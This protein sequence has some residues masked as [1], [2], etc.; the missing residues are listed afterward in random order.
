MWFYA[1]NRYQKLPFRDRPFFSRLDAPLGKIVRNSHRRVEQFL[2]L[3]RMITACLRALLTISQWF[4][5]SQLFTE[6]SQ[7][8]IFDCV[9]ELHKKILKQV[10]PHVFFAD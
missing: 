6:G 5:G 9:R 1:E 4:S 10:N 3:I 2:L 7:I 8:Q